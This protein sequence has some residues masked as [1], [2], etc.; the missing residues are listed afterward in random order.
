MDGKATAKKKRI[1]WRP[2]SRTPIH[3]SDTSVRT[4]MKYKT[5]SFF[6]HPG[7]VRHCPPPY[8]KGTISTFQDSGDKLNPPFVDVTD[9]IVSLFFPYSPRS[10]RACSSN[11]L[12]RSIRELLA[13]TRS[14]IL[15]SEELA[16]FRAGRLEQVLHW[17]KNEENQINTVLSGYQFNREFSRI[18]N[19]QSSGVIS[20]VTNSTY[21][22]SLH[23]ALPI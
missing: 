7:R 8:Y 6:R 18:A 21:T 20:C 17:Y 5:F 11:V 2:K 19:W 22:L 14:T 15:K 13:K 10:P 16:S 9:T 1:S 4:E 23:D 3:V 12:F